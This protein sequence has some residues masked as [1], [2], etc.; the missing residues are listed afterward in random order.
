[1]LL[2]VPVSPASV[3]TRLQQVVEGQCGMDVGAHEAGAA[4]HAVQR[5]AWLLVCLSF[6]HASLHTWR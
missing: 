4:S 6:S 1:M 2:K 3:M 5:K